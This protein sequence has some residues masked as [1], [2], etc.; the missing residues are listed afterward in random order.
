ML[1][2]R[3]RRWPNIEPTLDKYI[4]RWAYAGGSSMA[5]QW[6]TRESAQSHHLNSNFLLLSRVDGS[7]QIR[8]LSLLSSCLFV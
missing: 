1:G 6:P 7:K 8:K 3:L 4:G 2:Q 5:S